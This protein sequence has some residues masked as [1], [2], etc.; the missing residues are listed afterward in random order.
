MA[1]LSRASF[2]MQCFW[3]AEALFGS[4][5]GVHT[6]RVG[7]AGGSSPAPT[8]RNLADHVETV[9]IEFDGSKLSYEV[10]LIMLFDSSITLA[11]FITETVGYFLQVA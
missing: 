5:A 10:K 1:S 8:Y 9:D 7:Y 2:G 4:L 6:T 3:G 11:A